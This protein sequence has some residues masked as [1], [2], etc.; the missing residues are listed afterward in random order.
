MISN[1][2]SKI[3]YYISKIIYSVIDVIDIIYNFFN[4]K[5]KLDLTGFFGVFFTSKGVGSRSFF[6]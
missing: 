5:F 2:I 6:F 3:K 4:I 1:I